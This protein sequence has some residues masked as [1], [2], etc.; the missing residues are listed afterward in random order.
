MKGGTYTKALAKIWVRGYFVYEI[1][2]EMFYPN[3]ERF[4]WRRHAGAHLVELNM[5]DENQQKHLLPSFA[6]KL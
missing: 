5:V 2:E 3:L 4:V 6:I 1:S